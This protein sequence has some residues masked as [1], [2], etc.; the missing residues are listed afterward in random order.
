MR[1]PQKAI[2]KY[3]ERYAQPEA[4]LATSMPATTDRMVVIPSYGEG[5]D[6]LDMLNTVPH[7]H[8]ALVILVINE[9]ANASTRYREANRETISSLT[10]AYG[11]PR[12]LDFGA[13]LFEAPW[14]ALV[15]LDRTGDRALDPKR[16]VGLARTVGFD[17]AL[18]TVIEHK[19]DVAWLHGTDADVRLPPDFF[20]VAPP[21][22]DEVALV[23]RFTHGASSGDAI[24]AY[25]AYLRL[26]VLGLQRA[27]SPYAFHTIGSL[28]S[29]TPEAYAMVRG[30]PKRAAGEDFHF[31]NKLSKVG[32]VRSAVGTPIVLSSRHSDR[33]P[34]GTGPAL[35]AAPDD[36]LDYPVFHPDVFDRLADEIR[37][38]TTF[39]GLQTLQ[40]V[41]A[42]S[43]GP[44]SK[45]PLR[46]A[47]GLVQDELEAEGSGDVL[48][49]SSLAIDI[50]KACPDPT[51]TEE[52]RVLRSIQ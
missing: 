51:C 6:V 41:R 36:P 30:V 18:A 45:V 22:R 24:R 31:L 11:E 20:D 8:N 25:E 32:E 44:L 12:L 27:G 14:G 21:G 34:F 17:L 16:A 33:V 35:S 37:A 40:R 15:T 4:R 39:D 48:F 3:L 9:P 2:R 23:R 13:R 7:G 10:Q 47:L 49:L 5:A 52:K 46:E 42:L 50:D 28:I 43:A 38:G 19:L 1:H 29:V 26:Y